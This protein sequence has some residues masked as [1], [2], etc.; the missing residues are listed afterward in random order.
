MP[1]TALR[2]VLTHTCS[3]TRM[4]TRSRVHT[5]TP[6]C[7]GPALGIPTVSTYPAGTPERA[8]HSPPAHQKSGLP[9]ERP[10]ASHARFPF[11]PSSRS[12]SPRVSVLCPVSRT[13][14]RG[15]Q[16]RGQHGLLC[17]EQG[18]L[19][20]LLVGFVLLPMPCCCDFFAVPPVPLVPHFPFL[21][22]FPPTV[23]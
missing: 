11:L 14:P 5:R 3:H 20:R 22:C 21:G 4:Q 16:S 13:R 18:N 9:L 6:A 17:S 7:R 8:V 1:C 12:T 2:H 23:L 15:R 10:C 19:L